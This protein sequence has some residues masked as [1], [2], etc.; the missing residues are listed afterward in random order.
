MGQEN[1][2]TEGRET[3]CQR[4]RTADLES[5]RRLHNESLENR[6]DFWNE[7]AWASGGRE[8]PDVVSGLRAASWRIGSAG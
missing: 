6:E 7:Q 3:L 1:P 4:I 2:L 5:Y 8:S